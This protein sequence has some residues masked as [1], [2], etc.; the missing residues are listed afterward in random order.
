MNMKNTN[1]NLT[2]ELDFDSNASLDTEAAIAEIKRIATLLETLA[3]SAEPDEQGITTIGLT[4][5][6]LLYV[7]RTINQL[8]LIIQK[9]R[10]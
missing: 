5:A 6:Y 10:R 7:G 9:S 3:H 4:P 1:P 2:T 8:L